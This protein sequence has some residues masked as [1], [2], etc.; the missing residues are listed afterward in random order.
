MIVVM[1]AGH[2]TRATDTVTGTSA[3]EQFVN[4]FVTDVMPYVEKHYR[5]L[6]DRANTAIA[7]LSMGGGQTLQVA[8]PRLERF[9]YIGV[10][11]SGLLGA[12]PSGGRGA[13]PAPPAPA[14]GVPP[15]AI[16]WEKQHAAKLDDARLKRGLRLF[17]FAT[18][19][20]DFL[21]PT[22]RASV[23]LFKRHGVLAGVRRVAGRS[24]VDQLAQLPGRRSRRSCSGTVEKR[25]I[26]CDFGAYR[27]RCRMPRVLFGA[28]RRGSSVAAQTSTGPRPPQGRGGGQYVSRTAAAAW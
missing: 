16:E 5:V 19:T 17:W 27:S 11:S 18:G 2:V 20:E 15:A 22:T 24:H 12:F 7:G 1:P 9:A 21:M 23:E 3:T 8:I 10:F 6:T 26:E 25:C 4:D 14:G 13:T 28:G